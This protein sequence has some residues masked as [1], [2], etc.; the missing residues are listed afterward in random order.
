[1]KDL[2]MK[3]L[4]NLVV[5]LHVALV[6]AADEELEVEN[7]N[8]SSEDTVDRDQKRKSVKKAFYT[9]RGISSSSDGSATSVCNDSKRIG[10]MLANIFPYLT[11]DSKRNIQDI[12]ALLDE[13]IPEAI[14]RLRA[15]PVVSGDI[16]GVEES[17]LFSRLSDVLA[18]LDDDGYLGG[19][20]KTNSP[21]LISEDL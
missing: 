15:H 11:G 21:D 16:C 6:F 9:E 3:L 14:S 2:R 12:T 5:M 19:D 1:M 17:E 10:D 8:S 20:E 13:N 4:K 7:L 18:L